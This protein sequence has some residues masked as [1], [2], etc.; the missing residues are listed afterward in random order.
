LIPDDGPRAAPAVQL[1]LCAIRSGDKA[2]IAVSTTTALSWRATETATTSSSGTVWRVLDGTRRGTWPRL[3]ETGGA[4]LPIGLGR[5]RGRHST[6]RPLQQP[7][8][9]PHGRAFGGIPTTREPLTCSQL[10]V[11]LA[12]ARGWAS[13][14]SQR[15]PERP[16]RVDMVASGNAVQDPATV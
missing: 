11:L 1:V 7:P 15:R 13:A 6:V 14:A 3:T 9:R 4:G 16:S 10:D 12:R 8:V 5:G 2:I